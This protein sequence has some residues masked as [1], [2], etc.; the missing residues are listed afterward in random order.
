MI[1]NVAIIALIISFGFSWISVSPVHATVIFHYC[2]KVDGGT[3]CSDDLALCQSVS[4][5]KC[6]KVPTHQ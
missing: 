5:T 3:V 2:G 6:R 4:E 1:R